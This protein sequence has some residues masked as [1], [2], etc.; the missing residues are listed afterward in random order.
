MPVALVPT[1]RPLGDIAPISFIDSDMLCVRGA[2]ID[3]VKDTIP[4]TGPDVATVRAVGQEKGRKWAIESQHKYCMGGTYAEA[5]QRNIVFDL[6]YDDLGRPTQRGGRYDSTLRH[7]PR[8]ECTLP[9]Y[10]AQLNGRTAQLRASSCRD[11][12][13]SEKLFLLMVPNTAVVGD[14]IWALAGGQALYLLRPLDVESKKYMFIGECYAQGLMD[15]EVVR[16]LKNGESRLEDIVIIYSAATAGAND[17]WVYPSPFERFAIAVANPLAVALVC[18]CVFAAT[19]FNT[20]RHRRGVD[21][22]GPPPVEERLGPKDRNVTGMGVKPLT[23]AD[24]D[25]LGGPD[26][27]VSFEDFLGVP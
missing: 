17:T 14:A 2:Y 18:V 12:G 10:R 23:P 1:F 15:G 9:E 19:K 8:A 25:G 3:R 21:F 22:Y 11:L 20:R 27:D 6:V 5:I 24:D 13:L 16:M 26:E 4:N 7:R